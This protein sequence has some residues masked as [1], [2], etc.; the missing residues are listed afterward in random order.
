LCGPST[1]AVSEVGDKNLTVALNDFA[2]PPPDGPVLP[3]EIDLIDAAGMGET[4]FSVDSSVT[5]TAN[6]V[7]L[8]NDELGG[9]GP[10][11][12]PF[13]PSCKH[14]AWQLPNGVFDGG[15]SLTISIVDSSGTVTAVFPTGGGARQLS[16]GTSTVRSGEAASV[17]WAPASDAVTALNFTFMEAPDAGRG[18]WSI[19]TDGGLEV[20]PPDA[21]SLALP[22]ELYV[23]ASAT[24]GAAST[25][26]GVAACSGIVQLQRVFDV[27]WQ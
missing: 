19:D 4:C 22:G 21:G 16:L 11:L 25:C 23:N 6:G 12:G 24:I 1:Y 10:G 15:T 14:P 13:L 17:G 2:F 5:A 3:G 26:S 7:V 8:A 20:L 9:L 27:T 18:Y